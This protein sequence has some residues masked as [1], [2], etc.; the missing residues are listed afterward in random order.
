MMV[1]SIC[2]PRGSV[3]LHSQ[4]HT[5]LETVHNVSYDIN[6]ESYQTKPTSVREW[7]FS[8]CHFTTTHRL[9]SFYE[10]FVM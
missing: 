10:T 3:E 4:L 6:P 7:E 9:P 1:N 8:Q 5:D 2:S